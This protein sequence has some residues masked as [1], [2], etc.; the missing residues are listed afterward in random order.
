[1]DP[2]KRR[3]GPLGWTGGPRGKQKIG[4]RRIS[5]F[6]ST[7]YYQQVRSRTFCSYLYASCQGNSYLEMCAQ[8]NAED[9]EF[10]L[11]GF[12]RKVSLVLVTVLVRST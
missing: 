5:N 8:H 9:G 11:S 3:E 6:I 4:P 12:A 1:M 2:T 7:R 10:P